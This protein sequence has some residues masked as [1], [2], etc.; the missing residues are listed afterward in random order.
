MIEIK[1]YVGHQPAVTPEKPE[2]T[3]KEKKGP[4]KPKRDNVPKEH[5]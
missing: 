1:E 2:K 5:G 4:T 3:S